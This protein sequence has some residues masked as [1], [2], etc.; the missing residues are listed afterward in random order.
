M[1]NRKFTKTMIVVI[2][3]LLVLILLVSSLLPMLVYSLG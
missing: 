2:S 1:F 3:V